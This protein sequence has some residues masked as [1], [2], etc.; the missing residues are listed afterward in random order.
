MFQRST[1]LAPIVMYGRDINPSNSI[2]CYTR[3]QGY[4]I[5]T[6]I[7]TNEKAERNAVKELLRW[8]CG[9]GHWVY[10]TTSEE[11]WERVVRLLAVTLQRQNGWM[12]HNKFRLWI[13]VP[14]DYFSKIPEV[15]TCEC[16]PFDLVALH[17]KNQE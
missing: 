12:V 13:H 5:H 9:K 3:R 15:L 11:G 8:G 17:K 14:V 1:A 6:L 7:V 10:V 16:V 2:E 4:A